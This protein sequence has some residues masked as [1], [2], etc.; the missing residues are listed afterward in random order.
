LH[1]YGFQRETDGHHRGKRP[2]TP[3]LF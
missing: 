2:V 3:C 1:L